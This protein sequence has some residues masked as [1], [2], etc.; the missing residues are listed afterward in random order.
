MN[1]QQTSDSGGSYTKEGD[2]V[3][4]NRCVRGE[5]S[6]GDCKSIKQER[7][8]GLKESPRT[9]GGWMENSSSGELKGQT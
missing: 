6:P 7:I 2:E 8:W 1:Q 4:R 3:T 5:R 9:A